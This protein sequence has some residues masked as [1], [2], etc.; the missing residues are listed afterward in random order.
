MKQL[1]SNI[2]HRQWRPLQLWQ[3]RNRS[4]TSWDPWQMQLNAWRQ[5]LQSREGPQRELS[6]PAELRSQRLQLREAQVA[7]WHNMK[8]DNGRESFGSLQKSPSNLWLNLICTCMVWK[9][10]RLGKNHLKP[11]NSQSSNCWSSVP[12]KKKKILKAAKTYKETK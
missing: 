6:S 12:E 11:N 3:P 5:S 8:R 4:Q 9:S 10:T 2:G 1:L 7:V